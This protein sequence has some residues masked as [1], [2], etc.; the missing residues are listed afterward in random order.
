MPTSTSTCFTFE[1]SPRPDPPSR[2][3]MHIPPTQDP[4]FQCEIWC[5]YRI[6]I[7]LGQNL[8]QLEVL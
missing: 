7:F 4:C 5:R 2:I 8:L 3:H 1:F 6:P